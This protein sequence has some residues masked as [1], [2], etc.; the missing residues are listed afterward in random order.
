M[1]FLWIVEYETLDV[2][3]EDERIYDQVLTENKL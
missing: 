1:T 2:T 3:T